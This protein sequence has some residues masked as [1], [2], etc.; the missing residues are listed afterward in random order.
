MMDAGDGQQL[1]F[2]S[3][4]VVLH[5]ELLERTSARSV[6]RQGE[7]LLGMINQPCRDGLLTD[8]EERLLSGAGFALATMNLD[9]L[10][11]LRRAPGFRMAYRRH[12]HVVADGRPVIWLRRLAGQPVELMPGSELIDPLMAMAARHGVP[13]GFLGSTPEALARAAERL[14]A[15]HPRL[16]V[17]AQLSP[18]FGLDPEGAAADAAL[19]AL[20][21]SGARLVLVALGAPKQEILAIRALERMPGCG[22]VSVGAGLDFIAGTQRRAPGWMR[23]LALE[24]LWRL[25]GDPRRLFGR[26]LACFLILPGLTLAALRMRRGGRG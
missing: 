18:P 25:L 4:G 10:V 23:G 15:A 26:Y 14:Q 20:A 5:S 1:S 2:F 3:Q 21:A 12:S 8:L 16:Q 19:E 6:D 11:K 22:F 7:T 24:W 13:A 17:V 9:H